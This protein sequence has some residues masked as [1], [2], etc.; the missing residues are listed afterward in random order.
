MKTQA[1]PT[2]I[3]TLRDAYK[4]LWF[5]VVAKLDSYPILFAKGAF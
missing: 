5:R 4:V 3:K 2:P 1:E